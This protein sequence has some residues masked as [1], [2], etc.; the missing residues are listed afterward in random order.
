MDRVPSKGT[1]RR[2]FPINLSSRLLSYYS[3]IILGFLTASVLLNIAGRIGD[4]GLLDIIDLLKSLKA[5][6]RYLSYSL[7]LLSAQ[8]L[9]PCVTELVSFRVKRSVP[10]S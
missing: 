10:A 9:I 6:T 1:V 2:L 5:Y 8:R 3:S 4:I 7:L